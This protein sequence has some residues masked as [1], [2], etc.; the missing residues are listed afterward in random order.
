MFIDL[1]KAYDRIPRDEVWYCL[2]LAGVS[3]AYVKVIQD[4]YEGSKTM[5]RCT[6][7]TTK[8]FYVKVGLHQGSALSPFLFAVVMDQLT[9]NVRKETPWTMMFADDIVLTAKCKK[10]LEVGLEKWRYALESRGMKI[11]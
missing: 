1:E 9:K 4:M 6:V 7:G 8:A 11:S 5:V 3:E 2:R 10:D